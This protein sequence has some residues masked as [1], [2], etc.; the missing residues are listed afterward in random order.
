MQDTGTIRMRVRDAGMILIISSRMGREGVPPTCRQVGSG[1]RG[2]GI[3][4]AEEAFLGA[5]GVPA[6][7]CDL[8]SRRYLRVREMTE[9][10]VWLPP[11]SDAD[12]DF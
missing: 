12:E 6:S 10:A 3:S 8:G 11:R 7:R 1:R 9:A 2:N 4:G 5:R